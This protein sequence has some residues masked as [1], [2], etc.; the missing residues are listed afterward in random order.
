MKLKTDKIKRRSFF[1]YLAAGTAVM[2]MI[3]RN[4]VEIIKS[5]FAKSKS[6][7]VKENP[8]AVKRNYQKDG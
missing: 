6:V 4:S 7:E 8:L 5:K 1:K 2:Y 3:G